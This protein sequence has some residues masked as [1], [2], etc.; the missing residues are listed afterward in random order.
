MLL[1]IVWQ[2]PACSSH[3]GLTGHI[4]SKENNAPFFDGGMLAG[5]QDQ[6]L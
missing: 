5:V 2:V 4:R 1:P 6:A 3:L